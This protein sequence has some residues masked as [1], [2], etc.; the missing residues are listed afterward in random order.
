MSS[1]KKKYL[2]QDIACENC[3]NIPLL[4]INF[5]YENKNLSE[6]CELYSYCIY[7]DEKKDTQKIKFNDIFR[8]NI[9]KINIPNN[10]IKCEFCKNKYIQYH[11]IQCE[12]NICENC[13]SNHKEHRYYYNKDYISED[14]LEKI[15]N[16]LDESQKNLIKNMDLIYNK[17]KEFESQ[18]EELKN[19]Y[20]KY[21]DINDK[22]YKFCESI[23]KQ[24]IELSKSQ[25]DIYYPIYFNIKNILLF[26]PR[27]LNLPEND[28]SINAFKNILNEKLISGFYFLISNSN[29]SNNLSNYNKSDFNQINY[30]LL[31]LNEFN[32]K[33][34][35]YEKMIP[36]IQ[37]KIIG[38]KNIKEKDN[39]YL[40]IYNIKYKNIETKLN[41][42]P[43][44]KIFYNQEYNILILLSSHTL[45]ILNPKNFSIIQEFSAT[46][47]IKN[48][49]SKNK[50]SSLWGE[51]VAHDEKENEG[52]GK[53][54]HVEIFSKNS[55][56]IIF[57]GDI[58]RLG[59]EYG[60]FFSTDGLKVINSDD[61]CYYNNKFK[62]YYHLIIYEKEKDIFVP[63]KFIVLLRNQIN[64]NEV[65]TVIGKY[66][67]VYDE[68]LPYCAFIFDSMIKIKEDEYI[69][70]FNCKIVADRDQDYF[71]IKDKDYKNEN[72]F[73]RL[74]IKKDTKIK[75]KIFSI[76]G[77]SCL[78]KNEKYDKMYLLYEE[79]ESEVFNKNKEKIFKNAENKLFGI[80]IN[81]DQNTSNLIIEKNSL[82][83]WD[84]ENMYFGKI[85]GDKLEIID[86]IKMEK[87]FAIKFASIE[88]KNIFYH[89]EENPNKDE[90]EESEEYQYAGNDKKENS[91]E[92]SDDELDEDD[93]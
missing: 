40:D 51:R 67:E 60:H 26:N 83:G 22:L 82:I 70:V 79:S 19:L 68:D 6:V 75:E 25:E 30:D 32:K 44:K 43:P 52:D 12:R 29:F 80:K 18:L 46:H 87:N 55:F 77:K 42:K 81:K 13:F 63:K 17:I 2:F 62:D 58:R 23:L 20:L 37:N 14:E 33:E 31:N 90:S 38:I 88:E 36:F 10:K 76:S 41:L 65:D 74:N 3:S 59:E 93:M 61:K 8:K 45:Y 91:N 4:G 54:I 85:F 28:I 9:K 84:R 64:T 92:D 53:F 49:K 73:Y 7:N 71:Y 89:K 35:E 48:K 1:K 16:N 56:A 39:T 78:F 50:T 57:N 66:D 11:C 69:F 21:R 47:E 15:K 24:Y 34:I 86:T 27:Q 5:N 72:I